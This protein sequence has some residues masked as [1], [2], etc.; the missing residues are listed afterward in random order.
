LEGLT[1]YDRG[2]DYAY[3]RPDGKECNQSEAWVSGKGLKKGYSNG[4]VERQRKRSYGEKYRT[5]DEYKKDNNVLFIYAN[6]IND[7]ERAG[8]V[9]E[10]GYVWV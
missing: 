8:E 3:L 7:G 1:G 10:E 5:L 2:C 6:E 4:Y 9:P